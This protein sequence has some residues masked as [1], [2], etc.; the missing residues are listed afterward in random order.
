MR[1]FVIAICTF[2]F[3]LALTIPA[4][5]RIFGRRNCNSGSCSTSSGSNGCQIDTSGQRTS[6]RELLEKQAT[7]TEKKV[8]FSD[9]EELRIRE[10]IVANE[11][12]AIERRKRTMPFTYSWMQPVNR[13]VEP[14]VRS[15]GP[16]YVAK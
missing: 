2:L 3:V 9:D 14:A 15:G 16:L 11:Q 12:L 5:A 6:A 8:T 7:P 4:D 10:Q 1:S 13:S